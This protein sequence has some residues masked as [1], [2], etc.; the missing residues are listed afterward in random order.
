M[1]RDLYIITGAAGFLGNNLIQCINERQ[2]GTVCA[3]VLPTED[4][5]SLAGLNCKLAAG[6]VTKP[7]TL[8]K[9]FSIAT[10]EKWS[11]IFVVHCAGVIDISSRPNPRVPK[12]NVGGTMNVIEEC[13]HLQ[14]EG[15]PVRLL[16]VGSVHAIPPLP[17]G[18]VMREVDHFDPDLVTGQ[19]AKSKAEASQLVLDAGPQ[20]NAVIVEPSGILGPRDF[21]PEN[22]KQL[23]IEVAEGKLRACV[24]GGYNFVDVRD[25]AA[26]VL[27]ACAN[28]R[29]G[30]SYILSNQYMPILEYCNTICALVG[31]K[32]IHTLV[33]LRLARFGAPLSELYYRIRR[34]VPLFTSYA[35]E[36]VEVNSNFSHEKANK[37]LGYTVRPLKQTVKDMLR[38]LQTP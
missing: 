8:R 25:V 1:G 26:G 2:A 37:E 14:T 34:Q 7:E 9:A 38:W 19:Y 24:R 18:Q 3:V 21:S 22:M 5:G 10:A 29:S 27:A 33:P 13:L 31:R 17:D 4:R 36:T 28:G 16:Y 15:V 32:P 12:V 11:R 6:D 30:Q 23:M 20:L 35:L